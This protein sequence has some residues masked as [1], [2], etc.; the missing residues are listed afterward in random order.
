MNSYNLSRTTA[1]VSITH[2]RKL[3][4][5]GPHVSET[6]LSHATQNH[7]V[8]SAL[9]VSGNRAVPCRCAPARPQTVC[10]WIT[11]SPGAAA[12]TPLEG[13]PFAPT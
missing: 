11:A 3:L 9:P 6:A 10:S 5:S 1:R 7:A 4:F 2:P 8:F 12:C 13:A